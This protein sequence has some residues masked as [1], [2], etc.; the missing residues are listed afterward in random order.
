MLGWSICTK[1][2]LKS[3]TSLQREIKI[4][5]LFQFTYPITKLFSYETGVLNKLD[6][7]KY[8]LITLLHSFTFVLSL[9]IKIWYISP[10]FYFL[11]PVFLS[12]FSY[13]QLS[14]NNFVIFVDRERKISPFYLNLY[15]WLY[16]ILV[17][18]LP[19]SL[20]QPQQSVFW[21]WTFV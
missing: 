13:F 21:K 16:A 20:P 5:S 3:V 6:L 7:V 8:Q 2:L 1:S 15:W 14:K 19:T 11:K 18:T 4:K 17:I 9:V 10:H 12:F